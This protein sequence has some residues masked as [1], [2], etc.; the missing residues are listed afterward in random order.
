[1]RVFI[2]GP[3]V[4]IRDYLEQFRAAETYIKDEYGKVEIVNPAEVMAKLPQK[5]MWHQ[6]VDISLNMLR[7]CDAIFLLDGW[8]KS[9][10]SQIERLYAE[11][12]GMIFLFQGGA[13]FRK[14]HDSQYHWNG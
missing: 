9:K 8:E 1:M 12:C 6:Y 14:K 3:I 10:S 13:R 2:S 5:M 7:T 11:G 4:G